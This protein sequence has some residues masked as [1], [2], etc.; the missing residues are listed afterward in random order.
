ML[1]VSF[2]F[3]F[4]SIL[5]IFI[6]IQAI[7][8]IKAHIHFR[9]MHSDILNRLRFIHNLVNKETDTSKTQFMVLSTV[10][11]Q[12]EHTEIS[13]TRQLIDVETKT[14]DGDKVDKGQKH[15]RTLWIEKLYNKMLKMLKCSCSRSLSLST[16][17][18]KSHFVACI[19]SFIHCKHLLGVVAAAAAAADVDAAVTVVV[20]CFSVAIYD[21]HCFIR[22]HIFNLTLFGLV[23]C[24][25]ALSLPQ[26]I[27]LFAWAVHFSPIKLQFIFSD[28]KHL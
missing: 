24:A 16:L 12:T 18:V 26:S 7:G 17:P 20:A 13:A 23:T 15:T 8:A 19:T 6:K 5:E 2:V 25:I 14:V 4:W 28:V 9:N 10:I 21:L 22:V 1:C 11:G 3:Y 27:C